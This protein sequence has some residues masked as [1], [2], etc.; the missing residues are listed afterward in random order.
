MGYVVKIS[1]KDGRE[2]DKRQYLCI[3]DLNGD[4]KPDFVR[5]TI[6]H[7]VVFETK[8]EATSEAVLEYVN[9]F[10]YDYTIEEI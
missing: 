6:R 8:E 1:R 4:G 5:A 3:R 7:A 2:L 10:N 9:Y